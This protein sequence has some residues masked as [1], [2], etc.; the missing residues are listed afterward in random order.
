MAQKNE[1]SSHKLFHSR[2]NIPV[3]KNNCTLISFCLFDQYFR[4]GLDQ[5]SA[6]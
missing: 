6:I 3:I 2:Y 1:P 5:K 4:F